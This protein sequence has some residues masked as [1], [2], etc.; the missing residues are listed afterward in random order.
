MHASE[1]VELAAAVSTQGPALIRGDGAPSAA[2]IEQYWTG[3]KCRLDRWSR[4]LR[5]FT[6]EAEGAG[7][8]WR[9]ARWPMM[10]SIFEEILTGEIL[11]RVFAAVM[12]GYDR[13]HGS[14]MAGP[15]VQSVFIGH[16]E[17]RHRVLTIILHGPGINAKQA[18]LLNQLRRRAE[19]WCDMLV[20]YMADYVEIDKFAIDAE[21][22]LEFSEDLRHQGNATGGAGA[23]ALVCASLKKSFGQ[24]L[25][26]LSANADLNDK[27]AKSVLA[28]FP[29]DQFDSIGTLQTLWMVRLT[30]TFA[31]AQNMLDDLAVEEDDAAGEEERQAAEERLNRIRRYGCC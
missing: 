14:D 18:M 6:A 30:N 19:R 4:A 16:L 20:G 29:A 2:A 1:L 5:R 26:G 11:T 17:A 3:S 8:Q 10:R 24:G 31:D 15:A 23:W 21:R 25:C 22:A 13:R 7:P 9:Q 27:I 12:C 28:C